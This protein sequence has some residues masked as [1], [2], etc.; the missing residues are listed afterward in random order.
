M[1]KLE[2]T[3]FEQGKI[4]LWTEPNPENLKA[5]IVSIRKTKE[6]EEDEPGE[7]I[8]LRHLREGMRRLPPSTFGRTPLKELNGFTICEKYLEISEDARKLTKED[9]GGFD[10]FKFIYN[11]MEQ[12]EDHYVSDP[13]LV[14]LWFHE[15]PE[16]SDFY[17]HRV[18]MKLH[19][20]PEQLEEEF[21]E[22]KKLSS[23][24][25]PSQTTSEQTS[26]P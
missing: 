19:L 12:I 2:R 21:R 24:E 16:A 23:I 22:I 20:P 11:R 26:A 6:N 1:N 15:K 9:T 3:L 7:K 18:A 13:R 10:F 8:L 4:E 14:F 17:I 5:E 25:P